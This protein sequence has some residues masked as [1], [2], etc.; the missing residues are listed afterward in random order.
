MLQLSSLAIHCHSSCPCMNSSSFFSLVQEEIK[1]GRTESL[2]K[3]VEFLLW[4]AALLIEALIC[5]FSIKR[6]LSS[7]AICEPRLS[8]E[9]LGLH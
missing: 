7:P 3:K 1:Q 2:I 6:L 8:D 9:Q 4:L 5:F